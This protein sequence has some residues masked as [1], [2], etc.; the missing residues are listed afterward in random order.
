M[1]ATKPKPSTP[2]SSQ[3]EKLDTD[4]EKIISE[5]HTGSIWKGRPCAV[6][7]SL[8]RSLLAAAQKGEVRVLGLVA[9]E[10]LLSQRSSKV[11]LPTG[12]LVKIQTGFHLSVYQNQLKAWKPIKEVQ[13]EAIFTAAVCC[14]RSILQS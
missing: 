3:D 7:K 8:N 10:A 14:P 5:E 1:S 9:V 11:G 6:P 4:E 2:R 12:P 13:L